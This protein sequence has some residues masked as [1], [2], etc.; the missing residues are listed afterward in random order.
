MYIYTMAHYSA[1][2]N[3][4][5]PFAATWMH[6]EII[7]PSEVSQMEKD[8]YQVISLIYGNLE[9][10]DT[11]EHISKTEINPQT[12]KKIYGYQRGKR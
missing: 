5:M 7:I 9:K 11:N 12:K 6:S 8:K 4:I 2:K 1:I 3:E 10:N